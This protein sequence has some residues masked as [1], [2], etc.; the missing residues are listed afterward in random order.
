MRSSYEFFLISL[1]H[2]DQGAA[3]IRVFRKQ[4]WNFLG[5]KRK[6]LLI[7]ARRLLTP[8]HHSVS[9]QPQGRAGCER[10]GNCWLLHSHPCPPA[11]PGAHKG[12]RVK[13]SPFTRSH[14]R[15]TELLLRASYLPRNV[16]KADT[17]LYSGVLN[18]MGNA[19]LD[20]TTTHKNKVIL[21]TGSITKWYKRKVFLEY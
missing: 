5:P 20:Q 1:F 9:Q 12:N 21:L 2:K 10:A 14:H 4:F 13:S 15:F 18:Q 16:S 8:A 6:T 11:A 17:V 7:W 3:Q 19:D